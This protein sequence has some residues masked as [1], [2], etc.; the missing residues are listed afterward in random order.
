METKERRHMQDIEKKDDR[1]SVKSAIFIKTLIEKEVKGVFKNS[2]R[3]IE[4]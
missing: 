3:C 2:L 4:I 1:Y